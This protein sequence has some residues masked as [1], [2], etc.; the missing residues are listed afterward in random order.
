MTSIKQKNKKN[1]RWF[2]L[3]ITFL[4]LLIAGYSSRKPLQRGVIAFVIY[5]K[6]VFIPPPKD[7]NESWMIRFEN[8]VQFYWD[9]SELRFARDKR[10]KQF[11][12]S[13]KPLIKEINRR[14]ATGEGMQYSMNIYREIRW[15]LNFT[16]DTIN[17][18]LRIIDLRKSLSQPSQQ[19]L[20]LMQQSSDGSWGAGISVWYLRLYYSVDNMQDSLHPQYPF[21]ILDRINS[22]EKLNKQL[23]LDL[24]DDFTK[25]KVFNREELDETFSAVARLLKKKKKI[26]Y[27][28]HP[29]LDSALNDFVKHWQNTETG[30]WGQW[31]VDRHGKVWKMDDMGMTFHVITD[32]HGQVDQKDLIAKRLLELVNVNFPTGI[33][34]DGDYNNHLNWDAVKIFRYAWPQLDTVTREKVRTE[35][36][37]MLNWCLSKSF[38]PDGSFNISDLDD[39]MGDAFYYGVAFL[40]ET[41]YFKSKD[42]FWTNQNFPEAITVHDRIK[43]K[44]LSIGLNDTGLKDAYE[45][46]N[47]DY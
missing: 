28:F 44:I 18:R 2:I 47:E 19:K 31:L 40:N 1:K 27:T 21:S 22:P 29:Q 37:K 14:Q 10:V 4:I 35:I 23:E 33:K 45:T 13:L 8:N 25:T 24:Y 30:C 38:Q 3:F 36:S 42:R 12:P 15:R 41:G 43:A 26:A 39:T 9:I 6:H 34:F 17:T 46:L 32:L 7:T 16:S 5:H 20:G 11:N